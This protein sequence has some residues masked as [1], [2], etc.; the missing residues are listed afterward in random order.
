MITPMLLEAPRQSKN[1]SSLDND[2][3]GRVKYLKLYLMTINVIK[4]IMLLVTVLGPQSIRN[5]VIISTVSSV[6]LGF[7][8]L[9][10]FHSSSSSSTQSKTTGTD[11]TST[12][13]INNTYSIELQ[14]CNIAFINYWKAASY[15][16]SVCSAII[17]II[18]YQASEESFPMARLTDA[19]IISWVV[20]IGLFSFSFYRYHQSSKK[21]TKLLDDL[22]SYPFYWRDLKE[23]N[24][25]SVTSSVTS[26]GMNLEGDLTWI[27]ELQADSNRTHIP[28]Y[29]VSPWYDS[30]GR[31]IKGGNM[32]MTYTIMNRNKLPDKPAME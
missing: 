23:K 22:L 5:T 13:K 29:T 9:T 21:R 28:G 11:G 26:S 1:D 31:Y 20:I 16:A 18:A 4:S 7:L 30:K 32:S 12:G 19:L 3:T 10:W 2:D 27:S 8:T 15:S 25:S 6:L 14:P 17:I 24:T